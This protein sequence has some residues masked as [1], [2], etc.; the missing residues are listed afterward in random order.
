ME[1][2]LKLKENESVKLWPYYG[3]AGT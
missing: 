3:P 2:Y 1:T